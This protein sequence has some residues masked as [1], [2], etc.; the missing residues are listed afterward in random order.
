MRNA[1]RIFMILGLLAVLGLLLNCGG[2]YIRVKMLEPAQIF[3]PN[4]KTIAISDFSATIMYNRYK[5]YNEN[6]A[7]AFSNSLTQILINNAFYKVIERTQLNQIMAEQQLSISGL[8]QAG[9]Q[10]IGKLLGVDAIISGVVSDYSTHDSGE[11]VNV[12]K[13]N[14]KEKKYYYVKMY[15]AL[16]RARVE[17]TFKIIDITTGQILVSKS[18]SQEKTAKSQKTTRMASVN[19]LPLAKTILSSLRNQIA[20]NFVNQIAPH[21]IYKSERLISGKDARF[22]SGI[23]FAQGSLWDNAIPIFSDLTKSPNPK[24]L[25][26]AYYDLSI[27]YEAIG[28]YDKALR[29]ID[30]AL[31]Y[32]ADSF[33]IR[34]K[35]ELNVLKQKRAKLME[36]LY[37]K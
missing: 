30:S 31:Q 12:K 15:K 26:A 4:V 33:M 16:R 19:A 28:D 22:K 34:K 24:D 35:T 6:P 3:L 36:Q 32:G 21:T 29:Y 10:K 5:R 20:T 9:S 25:K 17:V 27:C 1:K 2:G 18:Y 13:Y 14:S 23:K 11:W 37:N 8:T 7:L